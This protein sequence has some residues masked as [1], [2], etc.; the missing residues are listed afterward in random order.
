MLH[1]YATDSDERKQIPLYLAGLAIVSAIGLSVL[2]QRIH[3]PG[4]LDVPAAAGFYGIYYEIFRR[5]LWRMEALH[6]WGWVKVPI[7]DGKWQGRVV[8]SFDEQQGKHPIEAEIAQDWTH[9]SIKM[10]SAYSRSESLVGSIFVGDDVVLDY[11]YRNEPLPNAVA[12]MHTHRGTASLL[13]SNDCRTLTGDYYSGRD[14][15][16]FG[17]LYLE[18]W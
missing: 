7:L 11:E 15:Q 10:R 17:F 1:P 5:W 4:W 12:T 2:L 9:I 6:K 16:N 18:R 3:L 8:T 14:R 13:V